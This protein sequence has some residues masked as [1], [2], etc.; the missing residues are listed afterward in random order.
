MK[1][2]ATQKRRPGELS[3]RMRILVLS[4]F[5]FGAL[6]GLFTS[7][8]TACQGR[9]D[10]TYRSLMLVWMCLWGVVA[11]SLLLRARKR[12]R[13]IEDAL[14]TA[15]DCVA[16]TGSMGSFLGRRDILW[17]V[18]MML[19]VLI[20]AVLILWSALEK[21]S[22]FGVIFVISSGGALMVGGTGMFMSQTNMRLERIT[23]RMTSEETTPA[24]SHEQ[25][26]HSHDT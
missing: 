22:A 19:S 3:R 9:W 11:M 7:I 24:A 17:T 20:L 21:H 26:D 4:A 10:A 8:W 25:G 5:S 23:K 2:E 15:D 18:A 16:P 14:D 13:R 6:V 1:E 12:L